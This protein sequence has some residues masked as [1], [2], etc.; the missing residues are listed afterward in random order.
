MNKYKKLA[1]NISI[2]AN[3]NEAFAMAEGDYIGLLDHDDLLAPQALFRM[4][5]AVASQGADMLYSDE[6]KVTEDLKKHFQPHFKPEFNLDLLRTNNYITHFLVVKKTLAE[7]AGLLRDEMN[8]AQDYDFIFRCS[9]KAEK[10]VRIPEI[11]YHWRTSETSTADNPMSKQYAYEAGARAIR[12]NLERSDTLG[13]VESLPDFG[14]YRVRY[15]VQG[16][17]LI[18]VIIPNKDHADMLKKCVESVLANDY[19]NVEIIIVENN[20]TERETFAYYRELSRD[21]RVRLIRWRHGFN[22]SAINNYGVRYAKGEYL[23]FLNNDVRGDISSD[24]LTEMLGVCQRKDVGAVGARLY[25][26]NNRIQHAGIVIGIG[27]VAGAM[28]VDLPKGRGG[29]M[30]KAAIMQDLSAVTAACML[31]K[32]EAF[33]KAGGFTEELAVAFNDV[34]LCL[35]I[36]KSGYRIV[37]DPFAELYHDESRTRGAEDTPEKVRRFQSEIEYMRV[38]WLDII[39]NGDPNYNPNLSLKKWNYSLRV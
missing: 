4:A 16:S 30:H 19:K 7:K 14:F 6:D 37:Y 22:Y 31:V 12:E 23:L 35:K 27:G 3:T 38:H 1:E 29:Y 17:P 10:I 2:S 39:K 21:P 15:P 33:E 20:S 5:E 36:G 9:E 26:P 24:W 34:D 18:S 28:F 8:G 11:L 25:Y 13:T 32:R